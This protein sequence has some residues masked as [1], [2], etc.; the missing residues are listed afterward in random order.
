MSL[1]ITTNQP[2]TKSNPNP[3]RNHTILNYRTGRLVVTNGIVYTSSCD[4]AAHVILN[5]ESRTHWLV[6][7][8]ASFSTVQALVGLTVVKPTLHSV[9]TLFCSAPP[10][11]VVTPADK[12]VGI[13]RQVAFRCRV[14]G[15]PTPAVFWSRESSEVNRHATIAILMVVY[16][17]TWLN[18]TWLKSCCSTSSTVSCM[19]L[20]KYCLNF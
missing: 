9:W 13:S 19:R 12:Q 3:N 1:C 6:C 5:C 15:N 10:S 2:D 14:T 16:R 4:P 8:V 7:D 17:P 20:M 11:F 18:L